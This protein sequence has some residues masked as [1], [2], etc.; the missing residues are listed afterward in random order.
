MTA[1]QYL[2]QLDEIKREIKLAYD[3]IAELRATAEKITAAFSDDYTGN[4]GPKDRIGNTVAKIYDREQELLLL[5]DEYNEKR[6]TITKQIYSIENPM[7]REV[8]IRKYI[9]GCTYE[10]IAEDMDYTR[11]NIIYIHNDAIKNFSLNFTM[12]M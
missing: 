1:K 12:D 4:T 8:L 9:M 5:V 11:R 10:K 7:F 6:A 3:E 2:L